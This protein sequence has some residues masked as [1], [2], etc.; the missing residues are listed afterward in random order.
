MPPKP[1]YT[2]IEGQRVK[3]TNLEKV[4]YPFHPYTKAEV[5]QYMLEVAPLMLPYVKGRPLTLIRFPDGIGNKTFYTK[6][7]PSWTPDWIPTV[8]IPWDEDNEY[9]LANATPHL[10]WLAN[11]AALEVHIMNSSIRDINYPDQFVID[12]DPPEDQDF[13]AVKEVAFALKSFLEGYGYV[14][15]AKLSGGKGIHIVVPILAKWEYDTMTDA[16]KE[17][18]KEFIKSNPHTTLSIAKTK[19]TDKILLDIYRNH[20]GNTT[21]APYSLRGKEGAPVSMPLT[22]K[23]LEDTNDPQAYTLS[24]ALAYLKKQ[25]DPWKGFFEKAVKLHNQELDKAVVIPLNE[26]AAKRD[27]D[28]TSEP[29]DEEAVIE[30]NDRFVIHLH[31]ATRLHYD[32]RLGVNKVL[33]SWAIPK[34]IPVEEGVK[35]LAIKT[36]DH[37]AKYIDFEG[38]IPKE[39]YGGGQM[40]VFDTGKIEWL[41]KGKTKYKFRLIGKS[42]DAT[43]SL[44]RIKKEE[45][46]IQRSET[47]ENLLVYKHRI[48]PML[49][50]AA[51][52][53]P[54]NKDDYEYEIKWDGIR[55]LYYKNGEEL[56]LISRSGRNIIEQF[57]EF[58][59]GKFIRVQRAILDCEIVCLDEQGKPVFSDVISRMHRAGK[60]SINTASKNKPAYL[61]AFDCLYLDGKKL[62]SLP[63]TRRKEWLNAIFKKS[64][65]TRISDTFEDGNQIFE[66]AKSMGLEGIMAKKKNSQY[67][68]GNRSNVWKKIKFTRTF[69]CHIIGYTKG[70]GDRTDIFGALHLANPEDG[71]WKYHG[72]VGTGFDQAKMKEIWEQLLQVESISKPISELVEEES[73]TTWIIPQYLCEVTYASFSSN[74]TLREPVFVKMWQKD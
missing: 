48:Q 73:K 66:A 33:K 23:E 31:H 15:F 49:C 18:M 27:F 20:P 13:Q 14:P 71:K 21:V 57:P 62:I 68:P 30:V 7:K 38:T 43:F 36:E 25:G 9:L 65:A 52:A 72:K 45:W 6:N 28:K 24:A 67:Y 19:R 58:Q 60:T 54:P 34:G 29:S 61:Y 5:I 8:Y 17:L 22:W 46:M 64:N 26:Y 39:E 55:V 44:Y 16:V 51:P 2:E 56:Q 41:Q 1:I 50:D 59:D 74:D 37:P 3:L 35:R 42:I 32:L 4:L 70:K 63:L 11:L 69:E 10:V 47:A 53:I 40:W 12:L